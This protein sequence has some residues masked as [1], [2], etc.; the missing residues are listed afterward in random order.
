MEPPEPVV[1]TVDLN[2]RGPSPARLVG[3]Q[4]LQHDQ[5]SGPVKRCRERLVGGDVGGE[6]L[7]EEG[8]RH[9][10][11]IGAAE[12]LQHEIA[13]APAYRR[14]EEHTSELQSPMYLV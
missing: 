7:A 8:G 11:G 12:T 14:S 10:N 5:R 13:Q 4:A 9:H 2:V 6:R 3:D 1:N